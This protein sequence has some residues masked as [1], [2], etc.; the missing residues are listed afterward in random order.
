M[1]EKHTSA[2]QAVKKDRD[3]QSQSGYHKT[4][5]QKLLWEKK[6]MLLANSM[7]QEDI[8]DYRNEWTGQHS[9][10]IH[11]AKTKKI[12]WK[13][14]NNITWRLQRPTFNNG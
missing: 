14:Y 11:E 3:R 9:S 13:T 5:S 10:K 2:M 6:N 12:H 4:I 8:H 1:T 7:P